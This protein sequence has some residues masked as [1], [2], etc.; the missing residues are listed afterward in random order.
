[1]DAN[2]LAKYSRPVPRYTSYPTAPQFHAGVD[3]ATYRSWLA[4]LPAGEPLSLYV[5]IPFCDSLCWF[6]GCSTR[7]VKRYSPLAAYLA[8]LKREIDMAAEALGSRRPVMHMHWGGGTPNMIAP[9]DI[10]ALV[11]HISERFDFREDMEFA[12]EIDP[13]T[14]T[15]E[16]VDAL[17][18]VGVTRASLGVQDLNAEV[19]KA[20]NRI[21]PFEVT[22]RAVNWLRAAGIEAINIDLM[23][24]LPMQTVAGVE[25]T[26][27]GVLK[28]APDRLALFG[29]AHVPWM[30]RHQ[31]LIDE[32]TLPDA[33]ERMAQCEAT[34]ARLEAAGYRAIGLDHFARPEDPLARAAAEGRL[35]RNFQGYTVDAAPALIGFGATAIGALPQGYVQNAAPVH[36]WR[37]AIE[38]GEFAIVRGL[39]LNDDD[40]LRRAVIERLMCD[41]EVD[42]DAVCHAHGLQSSVLAPE[43][44][45]LMP[46]VSDGLVSI[47]GTRVKVPTTARPLLRAVATAFDHYLASGPG[48]H[49]QAV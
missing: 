20:V 28:L 4:A 7:I 26:V 30:K 27:D 13:R 37:D 29:Y 40:R 12:V 45:S 38:G 3:A 36:A 11:G 1:M 16:T 47:D 42:L 17:A 2:L 19:Q 33:T 14:L 18:A 39:A 35:R 34:T 43:I 22:E 24:G 31:G 48:R 10:E 5:H 25:A 15:G 23:Y 41:L 8:P 6:C 32:S 21:Q 9:S 44:A 46:M 49:S